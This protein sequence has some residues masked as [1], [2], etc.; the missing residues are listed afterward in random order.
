LSSSRRLLK[1]TG[2]LLV[3]DF[4][5]SD[6]TDETARWFHQLLTLLTECNV[7]LSAEDTFGRKLLNGKGKRSLWREHVHELNT[8]DEM[9]K[10]IGRHFAL[11]KLE[12]VPY[13]YRYVAQM[14][15]DD[16]RGGQILSAVLNLERERGESTH[17]FLIGRRFVAAMCDML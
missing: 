15:T 8:A 16:E 13:L 5:Y 4:A 11:K 10:A 7:L 3:E 17:Q 2:L 6:T 14:L 12:A 1:P 9:S